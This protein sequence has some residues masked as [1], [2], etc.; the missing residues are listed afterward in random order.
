MEKGNADQFKNRSLEDIDIDM[1]NVLEEENISEY[2][3]K[4]FQ[5][6]S[7]NTTYEEQSQI[8]ENINTDNMIPDVDKSSVAS[9]SSKHLKD[10]LHDFKHK[11]KQQLKNITFF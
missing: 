4:S 5:E 3:N 10:T 2:N 9:M 8:L 6:T 7:K 11:S 1:E